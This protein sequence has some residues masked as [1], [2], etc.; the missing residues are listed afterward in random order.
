LDG[1]EVTYYYENGRDIQPNHSTRIH[2]MA[3]VIPVFDL[4]GVYDIFILINE[5]IFHE[6]GN[7]ASFQTS[8]TL[9]RLFDN[10]LLPQLWRNPS[11]DTRRRQKITAIFSL[12]T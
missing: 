12:L 4:P 5:G 10:L 9:V 1:I 7:Q 8:D 11:S 6:I 2:E 3:N